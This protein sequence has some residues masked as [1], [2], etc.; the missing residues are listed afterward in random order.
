MRTI[1]LL[2]AAVVMSSG[3]SFTTLAADRPLDVT[4]T[5][6]TAQL[7][8]AVGGRLAEFHPGQPTAVA[9]IGGERYAITWQDADS[10]TQLVMTAAGRLLAEQ[11]RKLAFEEP[12]GA[13]EQTIRLGQLPEAVRRVV[14]AAAGSHPLTEL[15]AVHHPAGLFYEAE[16]QE[17]GNE[18]EISVATGGEIL[19]RETEAPGYDD[20]EDEGSEEGD[21]G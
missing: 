11:W 9:K 3:L 1:S 19:A 8:A 16:W 7:P 13:R 12:V 14:D 6:G 2:L 18:V 17:G 4:A 15:E 20:R 10:V 5:I 21:D